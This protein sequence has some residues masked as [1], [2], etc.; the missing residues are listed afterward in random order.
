MLLVCTEKVAVV[1]GSSE[2]TGERFWQKDWQDLM[3]NSAYRWGRGNFLDDTWGFQPQQTGRY[4]CLSW[5]Q[6]PHEEEQVLNSVWKILR[7]MCVRNGR[8][9]NHVR[10]QSSRLE[11]QIWKLSTITGTHPQFQISKALKT[12]SAFVL[13]FHA[14]A[15][16][17]KVWQTDLNF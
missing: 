3:T 8:G 7:F 6:R 17:S 4:W 12:E 14:N 5:S 11:R 13:K 10:I 9:D 15:F 16:V 2:Y 1:L